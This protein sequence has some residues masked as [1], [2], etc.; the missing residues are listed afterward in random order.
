MVTDRKSQILSEATRLFSHYGYDK[1]TIKELADACKITEPARYR[2]FPSKEAIYEAVLDSLKSALEYDE[3][4]RRLDDEQD[5]MIIM[6][7]LAQH[8]LVF[9]KQ[10]RE[11]YRLLLYS[12]LREHR[13]A[14]QVFRAI[15]SPFV[16]FLNNKLDELRNQGLVKKKNNQITARCF[17][18]M[19]FDCALNATLWKGFQGKYFSPEEVIGNNVPIFVEGLKN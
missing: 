11:L 14:R 7:D 2:Y 19:V 9:F 6:H 10:H 5:L 17:I 3:L 8:I 4:F 13:K 12:T 1:V 15:R 18:G 16:D